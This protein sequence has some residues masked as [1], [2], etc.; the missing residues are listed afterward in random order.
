MQKNVWK[1]MGL[2]LA[3]ACGLSMTS[4][5]DDDP[6]TPVN[7]DPVEPKPVN[8]YNGY[9]FTLR[10]DTIIGEDEAVKAYQA[11]IKDSISGSGL[12]LKE[13]EV[14]GTGLA[15]TLK[16]IYNTED[17]TDN[18]NGKAIASR[19]QK[20]L[21]NILEASTQMTTPV[22]T[23]DIS[24]AIRSTSGTDKNWEAPG[25]NFSDA[26]DCDLMIPSMDGTTWKAVDAPEGNDIE[27]LSFGVWSTPE[28]LKYILLVSQF[29]ING[30]KQEGIDVQ[31]QGNKVSAVDS[32]GTTL[33]GFTISADGKQL[34][35]TQ[36]NGETLESDNQI[37]FE[38]EKTEE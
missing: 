12:P 26:S 2:A 5:G 14:A 25:T 6:I 20:L 37:V 10:F 21:V 29:D 22:V 27:Q 17:A 18:A 3:L 23:G 13:V 36:R 16:I 7:P 15:Y 4:C 9:E 38:V 8:T 11:I 34:I 1:S 19:S 31:R 33:Y 32:E 30:E 24:Y 28:T 35:M